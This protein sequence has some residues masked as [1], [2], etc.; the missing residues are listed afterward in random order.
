[1]AATL[2]I[3]LK[4]ILKE[5]SVL[6]AYGAAEGPLYNACTAWLRKK[7]DHYLVFIEADEAAFLRA[8]EYPLARDPQVRL[9][10]YSEG[11]QGIFSTIAWEFLFLK[12]AYLPSSDPKA[13]AFFQ[14]LASFEHGVTL[15][16]SDWKDMGE[17]VCSN[18]LH[19]M[20]FLSSS[21]LGASLKG[22]CS[23][24]PAIICGAGA[25]LD[26]LAPH[27]Q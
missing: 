4:E 3:E 11:D 20:E 22:A 13:A 19:N 25:S 12:M 2:T 26:T 17:R 8:K 15:L 27:L 6:C 18:L 14:E 1:M 5:C 23:N 9:L 21:L 24:M 10:F 7:E 16:A